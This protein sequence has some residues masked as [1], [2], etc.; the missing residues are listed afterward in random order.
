LHLLATIFLKT[1]IQSFFCRKQ[2]GDDMHE[3]QQKSGNISSKITISLGFGQFIARNQTFL[4]GCCSTKIC[5]NR[6][7]VN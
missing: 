7:F 6:N 2:Q 3:G 4:F 1:T 5:H